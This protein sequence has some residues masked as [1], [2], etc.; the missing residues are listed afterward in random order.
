MR[1]ISM[2]LHCAVSTCNQ[3]P[4]QGQHRQGQTER[5]I[6]EDGTAPSSGLHDEL[7]AALAE[8]LLLIDEDDLWDDCDLKSK[9]TLLPDADGPDEKTGR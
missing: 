5:Q 1:T 2:N 3:I 9:A 7:K 8:V 6:N 4:V